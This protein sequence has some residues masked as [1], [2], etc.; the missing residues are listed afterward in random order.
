MILWMF[1]C[2]SITERLIWVMPQN[3]KSV[4]VIRS[5]ARFMDISDGVNTKQIKRTILKD[6]EIMVKT[7]CIAIKMKTL[8]NSGENYIY[9]LDKEKIRKYIPDIKDYR[10]VPVNIVQI[11]T[12][13][14]LGRWNFDSRSRKRLSRR[15]RNVQNMEVRLSRYYLKNYRKSLENDFQKIL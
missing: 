12:Y 8:W 13:Y 6:Y 2:L 5:N 10:Y 1:G 7:S 14:S 11:M 9:G 3:N 4:R 15:G